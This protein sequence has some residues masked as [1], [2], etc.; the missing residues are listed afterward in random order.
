[1]LALIAAAPGL[2]AIAP[3]SSKPGCRAFQATIGNQRRLNA[4]ASKL[5]PP[6]LQVRIAGLPRY[7]GLQTKVGAPSG[8]GSSSERPGFELRAAEIRRSNGQASLAERPELGQ[9]GSRL[10]GP[11]R[12]RSRVEHPT[13][14]LRAA[15]LA[16]AVDR[17]SSARR[18]SFDPR[19]GK[20]RGSAN[21]PSTRDLAKLEGRRHEV[22]RRPGERR[23]PTLPRLEA[24]DGY[25]YGLRVQAWKTAPPSD[26][27]DGHGG[28]RF[29]D[30]AVD[31]LPRDIALV[32]IA[33]V[34]AVDA[35]QDEVRRPVVVALAVAVMGVPSASDMGQ[36]SPAA[37][38]S[39]ALPVPNGVLLVFGEAVTRPEPHESSFAELRR[40]KTAG[41]AAL[42]RSGPV[43]RAPILWHTARNH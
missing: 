8:L 1:M 34:M 10:P 32:V 18:R 2:P 16:G 31:R 33:V 28:D 36:R 41:H 20:V 5:R 43:V 40:T 22:G 39:T 24:A 4:P 6:G 17:I 7:D 27:V 23:I 21:P 35:T 42:G 38:T 29:G 30:P 11:T 9:G 25:F 37:R 14:H 3:G 15:Q 13:V 19:A 12:E 26:Q